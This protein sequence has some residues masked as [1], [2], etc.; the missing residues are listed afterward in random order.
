MT[1]TVIKK[2]TQNGDSKEIKKKI[3]FLQNSMADFTRT[4]AGLEKELYQVIADYGHVLEKEKIK[5]IQSK[6]KHATTTKNN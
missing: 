6:L 2:N 1:G 5:R 4:L 3:I